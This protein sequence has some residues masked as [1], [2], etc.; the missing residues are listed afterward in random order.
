MLGRGEVLGI[1]GLAGSGLGELAKAIFGAAGSGRTTGRVVVD[2][3]PVASGSPPASL[4]AGIA[5]ITGDRRREGIFPDFTLQENICLPILG[6]F[7]GFAGRLDHAAM[8]ETTARNLARLRV[9]APGP[10]TR[11][12][13]L[14]GGNQQKVVFAKWLE[15]LPKVFVMDEPTIGIDVGSKA[16]IRDIIDEIA[17]AG[18]GVV[19]ITT[20]LEEL[21][22][23]CDRVLV[24]FRG[25]LV[26]ELTGVR[27]RARGH[28]AR[29]GLRREIGFTRM[30]SVPSPQ[31]AR[32]VL[33]DR[34]LARL[35]RSYSLIQALGVLVVLI[36]LMQIAND[37]FL[38]PVNIGNLLGQMTVMLIVAA[39]MTIIMISGEFDVAVGSVVGLSAAV[40]GWIMVRWM[41][42]ATAADQAGWVIV[43]GLLVPLLVGPL[44]GLFAGLVVTK[45]LIPSFIVTLGTLM[46]ARSL[47]LVVTQGQPIPDIPDVIRAIGQG[48][49]VQLPL[50]VSF[51]GLAESGSLADL[52]VWLPIQNIL[53][54]A[55]LVYAI[56]WFVMERTA[57]G[58]RVYAVGANRTVAVLSGIRA[59][60]IKIACFMIVGFTA[61]LA[62][63][64][65]ISRLGAV[66]PN[67]G[68]G[69]EFEVIA[70][71]VI[72]GTSLSGG[73]GQVLRT[74]IGVVII[75]LT[76]NFLN[77]ARIEVFW[78]GFAT[79]GII[80]TAVL[81]E[82][83][84]RRISRRD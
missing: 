12:R 36:V 17:A 24:M 58:K 81:L 50:P 64:V 67:T 28:P 56:A 16:E 4:A 78:Q 71:V 32:P 47:T 69:L 37:R 74:I 41:P 40:A 26:A 8:E 45:A 11:A 65:S 77:L 15:T 5:L 54:V 9:R 73:Q 13:Q 53:W 48:R 76:R 31:S 44:I 57:F 29:R 60:R 55:V 75:V 6:R 25:E 39:G 38:S 20:E 27:H 34:L 62:G 59:D 33:A 3:N 43:V 68:E 21:V 7:A 23:L 35:K 66:S 84:Q 2:G 70:A 10:Q 18:V 52:I 14:S 19:L 22:S 82:A 1:T 63:L 72:G 83:L 80:L 42:V 79:G 49:S 46:M 61:S 51:K 30:T